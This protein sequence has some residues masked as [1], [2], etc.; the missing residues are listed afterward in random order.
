MFARII[1]DFF[2]KSTWHYL[3]FISFVSE[4]VPLVYNPS[5]LRPSLATHLPMKHYNLKME[6]ILFHYSVIALY[7]FIIYMLKY[8]LT[9]VQ[10]NFLKL[11]IECCQCIVTTLACI[12][13]LK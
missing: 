11:L 3:T 12:A 10:F 6:T 4:V 8:R 13:L 9:Y 7:F 5:P 2:T 1:I